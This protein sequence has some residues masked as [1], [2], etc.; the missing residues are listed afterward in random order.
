MTS[1]ICIKSIDEFK[2]GSIYEAELQITLNRNIDPFSD[3][4]NEDLFIIGFFLKETNKI[5]FTEL[6]TLSDWREKQI[7][8]ILDE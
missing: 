2:K 3:F 6:I 4:S 7:N 1:V 8:S 5:Y